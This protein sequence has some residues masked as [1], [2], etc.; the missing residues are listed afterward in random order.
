M[1]ITSKM[2][3]EEVGFCSNQFLSSLTLW[4]STGFLMASS[5]SSILVF[6]CSLFAGSMS[7]FWL[8]SF[9]I[10][11]MDTIRVAEFPILPVFLSIE[12]KIISF[13]MF[14]LMGVVLAITCHRLVSSVID[15]SSF[16]ATLF[17]LS[18]YLSASSRACSLV[19]VGIGCRLVCGLL[20]I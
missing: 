12:R 20:G 8:N 7:F 5:S 14:G 9:R 11:V 17:V 2:L 19:I 13:S 1:F 6:I 3:F 15:M 4:L 16:R 10:S 18:R